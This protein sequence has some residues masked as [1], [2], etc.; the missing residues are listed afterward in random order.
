[1]I[2][3]LMELT[4]VSKQRGAYFE[5]CLGHIE[6][7]VSTGGKLVLKVDGQA[8]YTTQYRK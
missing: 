2:F 7:N 3:W 4:S 5:R 1:M 8:G 6:L